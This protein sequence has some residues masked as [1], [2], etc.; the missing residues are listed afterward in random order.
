MLVER[1]QPPLWIRLLLLALLPLMALAIYLHGQREVPERDGAFMR[2]AKEP[3]KGQAELST[4]PRVLQGLP[5]F[6]NLR[7]YSVETLYE[8][9]NGHA[10][11]FISAGFERLYVVEFAP[12]GAKQPSL[13]AEL[14]HMG[15]PLQAFGVLGDETSEAA[16][17]VEVGMMALQSGEQIQ[18]IQGPWY[19]LFSRYD[20]KLDLVKAAQQLAAALPGTEQ[21][22]MAFDFPA[23]GAFE[24]TRYIREAYRGL[25]FFNTVVERYYSKL[26][27]GR[28][29]FVIQ[30]DE[31]KLSALDAQMRSF[32]QQEGVPMTPQS[33]QGMP[34]LALEDKYEGSWFIVRAPGRL[35]GVWGEATEA[36]LKPLHSLWQQRSKAAGKP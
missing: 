22:A 1:P 11:A 27:G 16:S 33:W 8:Y 15:T 10:E 18:F 14:Y 17:P 25:D 7:H 36:A 21:A 35:W 9:I 29:V 12:E 31:A 19:G 4:L 13:V 28:T 34:Y 2:K 5:R 24:E 3:V 23:W 26:D 32:Y 6:G 30:Q 20:P